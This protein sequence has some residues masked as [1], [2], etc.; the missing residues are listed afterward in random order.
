MEFYDAID[1]EMVNQSPKE[2]EAV[3]DVEYR[4]LDLDNDAVLF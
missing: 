3:G 4:E 1:V 2:N